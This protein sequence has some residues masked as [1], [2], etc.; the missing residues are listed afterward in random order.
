MTLFAA[1]R[2][3]FAWLLAWHLFQLA[4][5]KLGIVKSK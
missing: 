5:Q 3:I 2:A 1:F 4:L